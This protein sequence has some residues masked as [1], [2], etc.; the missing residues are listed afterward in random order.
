VRLVL[1]LLVLVIALA[2]LGAGYALWSTSLTIVT[3]V[4]TGNVDID[5]TSA[6][7]SDVPGE[8][9]LGNAKDVGYAECNILDTDGDGASEVL[10]ITVTDAYPGYQLMVSDITVHGNGNVPVHI[11]DTRLE[12]VSDPI[13]LA[14]EGFWTDNNMVC[15]QLHYSDSVSGN[16]W[17]HVKQEAAQGAT[18]T[19]QMVIEAA[20]W[21]EA[22]CP[23]EV[24]D[25]GGTIGFWKNWDSHNTYTQSEIE[26]WLATSDGASAW[27]GPTTT[28][29]MESWLNVSKKDPMEKQFLA[30]CRATRMDV[31]SGR[32]GP[33]IPHDI[34]GQDPLN[35]LGVPDPSS[36]T[37]GGTD[38]I[39]SKI[40]GKFGTSPDDSEFEVMKDVCDALNNLEI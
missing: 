24:Q 33:G 28:S 26:I 38:G 10:E 18:Y 22:P 3:T 32:L 12:Y 7:C 16:L 27:L 13:A 37:L 14:M 5:F 31:E 30:H 8:P 20:Q 34:T 39:I 15:T 17:F 11:T 6:T 19:F 23:P 35:Y 40:E 1:L 4:N 25:L 21:N 36:A 29:D 9:D 2:G